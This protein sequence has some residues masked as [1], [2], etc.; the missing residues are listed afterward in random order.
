MRKLNPAR[1]LLPLALMSALASSAVAQ[2]RVDARGALSTFP[3]SQAVLFVN[4]ERIVNDVLPKLMRPAD[5]QKM[6]DDTKKVGFDVRGLQFAAVGVRFNGD[7]PA[8]T[9][10]EFVLVVK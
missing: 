10:P 4:A 1:L 3:D 9:P 6:L 8:G 7:V 5:Y 2:T